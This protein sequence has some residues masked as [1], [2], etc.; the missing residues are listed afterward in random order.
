MVHGSGEWFGPWIGRRMLLAFQP[1]DDPPAD[2]ARLLDRLGFAILM[3]GTPLAGLF[4]LGAIYVL[5]P[6]GAVLLLIA[7]ALTSTRQGPL[8]VLMREA[9][10]SVIGSA[11]LFLLGWAGLSL[12]WTPFHGQA[13]ERFGKALVTGL[14]VFLVVTRLPNRTKTSYLYMLPLGLVLAAFLACALTLFGPSWFQSGTDAD[15]SL[16]QRSALTIVI[17]VWPALGA[18]ALRE[19]WIS[20]AALAI[21]A[22][23]TAITSG[24][25]IV[26]AAMAAGALTYSLAMTAPIRTSRILAFAFAPLILAAPV[27]VVLARLLFEAIGVDQ[28]GLLF[29]KLL[30]PT[31]IWADIVVNE[32]P[33]LITGHGLDMVTRGIAA[34][35]LSADTPRGLLFVL[36]FEL[37]VL[38]AIAFAV[39]TAKAFLAAGRI[40]PILAPSLLAGLAVGLI[41]AILGLAT[42][43]LWWMTLSGLD[44][45][46]FAILLRGAGRRKRLPAGPIEADDPADLSPN[47]SAAERADDVAPVLLS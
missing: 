38:G 24:A 44:A 46:A 21:A 25:Q 7:A 22:A 31:F 1:L 11:A 23:A 9:V 4:W 3:I 40:A 2:A 20:A 41:V 42:A 43:Q 39:L 34:G 29:E 16:I 5:L 37:G 6:V 10:S 36:W 32:W 45:I 15:G 8:H 19:H 30:A 18:L 26:L 14:L 35:Y 13:E 17:L 27:I 12:V 33:R 28:S 47:Y